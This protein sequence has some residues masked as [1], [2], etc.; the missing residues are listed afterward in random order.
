[1]IVFSGFVDFED[2]SYGTLLFDIACAV[3]G[4]CF[5]ESNSLSIEYTQTFIQSYQTIRPLEPKEFIL[6]IDF[7]KALL[8]CNMW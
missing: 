4:N 7:L 2:I 5:T 8:L 6:F 1:M 3:A